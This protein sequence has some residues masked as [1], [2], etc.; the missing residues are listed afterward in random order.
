MLRLGKP[1]EL[2]SS[3]FSICKNLTSTLV[4]KL[5][6]MTETN[7][8]SQDSSQA[9][10]RPLENESNGEAKKQKTENET[11]P[12]VRIKR[13]N[14]AMMLGYLGK[15]YYGM[16]RNPKID[17][18][19]EQ[20]IK[21]MYKANLITSEAV[22]V[23]QNI[24]FQRAART[25][26]GVSAVRQVVSLKLPEN[27]SKDSINEHLPKNIKVFSIKRV[28][29]GFNCKSKCNARTYSYTLPTYAFAPENLELFNKT[30]ESMEERIAERMEALS[31][32][33]GKPFH[34]YRLPKDKQE[35]VSVLLQKFK[36]T[37]NFHNYTTKILPLDPRARRY[38]MNLEAEKPVIVNDMEFMTLKI[39]GQSFMMH[40]I[41]KMV[42]MVIAV[43]RNIA[44]E[45]DFNQSFNT[46]KYIISRAPSL[47]LMLNV[48]H[49]DYY[50][51][52]YGKDGLHERL[53]WADCEEEIQDFEKNYILKDVIDTEINEKSMLS[54][55]AQ[56][57]T[58]DYGLWDES[59]AENKEEKEEGP[60]DD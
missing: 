49:Y 2:F 29:K 44:T 57:S 28:T 46:P 4:T 34:E 31:L 59:K 38:I 21:A 22:E 18:I 37:K 39:K 3:V 54:W 7:E 8:A 19:E 17:T 36:G 52:R 48:V 9:E 53:D 25:D 10:K 15:D 12:F 11:V 50:N 32:I 27:P 55:L 43:M 40:Q 58:S 23:I 6:T 47:G 24:N 16:Q 35:Q 30:H 60:L 14:F 33:D 26:K 51:E 13:R 41:R 1:Q 45:E 20:L 42:S 56:L 5:D